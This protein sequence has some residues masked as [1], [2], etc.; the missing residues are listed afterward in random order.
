MTAVN[1]KNSRI[2]SALAILQ[3][4]IDSGVGRDGFGVDHEVV[5]E[6][7]TLALRL[8]EEAA[9]MDRAYLCQDRLADLPG[10]AEPA[11]LSPNG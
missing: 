3:L 2:H 9:A 8:L 10:H 7:L 6:S 11:E 5:T 1:S 4:L